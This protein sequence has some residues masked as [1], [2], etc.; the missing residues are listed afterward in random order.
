MKSTTPLIDLVEE[1]VRLPA[2]ESIVERLRGGLCELIDSGAAALPAAFTRC[3]DD[4]Y[5]RRLVH[6]NLARGYSIVAMAWGPRQGTALHDHAGLW[7]V[8]SVWQGSIEVHQYELLE[9]R[10]GWYRFEKCGSIRA[11]I[12]SAGCLIPPHEYHVI[13][14]PSDRPAVS[15]HIYGGSMRYCNVFEDRG[16]GWYRRSPKP[17]G[18]DA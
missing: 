3:L 1:A 4:H 15:V 8:E 18:L 11:G 13:C 10:D 7:C 5:A 9:Q 6:E 17:L 2:V 12:G 16:D 14:N